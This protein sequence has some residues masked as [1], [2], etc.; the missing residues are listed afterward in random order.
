MG[1]E[2]MN[3]GVSD[4]N[5]KHMLS[6]GPLLFLAFL[7]VILFFRHTN[8]EATLLSSPSSLASL[9]ASPAEQPYLWQSHTWASMKYRVLFHFIVETTSSL[10]MPR[11][12]W[13]F[14]WSFVGWSFV[15][16]CGTLFALWKWLDI[17]A[18]SPWQRFLGCLL[19]L[20]SFPVVFAYDYPIFTREDPLAYLLIV[21]SLIALLQS[22]T[23]SFI[24][25]STLGVMTRETNLVVPLCHLLVGFGT[26]RRR[27]TLAFPSFIVFLMLRVFLGYQSY[28][29]FAGGRTN[30]TRPLEAGIFLFL[31]FGVIWL[32]AGL[33]WADSWKVRNLLPISKRALYF[34]TP[35]AVSS[36]LV[37]NGFMGAFRENRISFLLFPFII[38][39]AIDWVSSHSREL[40]AVLRQ[41]WFLVGWLIFTLSAVILGQL[42]LM[43]PVSIESSL[44]VWIQ[45]RLVG[46]HT[47]ISKLLA[48]Y[49]DIRWWSGYFIVQIA[50]LLPIV[51]GVRLHQSCSGK[52]SEKITALI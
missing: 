43:S 48:N 17:L 36:I 40:R 9:L 7:V 3:K 30:L 51:V 22:H 26:L 10:I 38:P 42:M 24:L 33:R 44:P 39:W 11:D 18:F 2:K 29:F 37:A 31:T 14:Y 4:K 13:T 5:K 16:T 6:C 34:H 12:T 20:S 35:V 25:F 1:A 32:L 8:S 19:F 27:M 50:L 23:A 41:Q 15:F 46:N 49:P 47:T 28:D 52:N 21:L 45:T